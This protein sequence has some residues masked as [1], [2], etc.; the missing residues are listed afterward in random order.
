MIWP[1]GSLAPVADLPRNPSAVVF[2]LDGTLLDTEAGWLRAGA[3][4]SARYGHPFGADE[5]RLFVG[6]STE[7]ICEIMARRFGLPGQE[8]RLYDELIALVGH[9]LQGP[10]VP[11]PGAAELVAALAGRIPIA[12]ATN[13]TRALLDQVLASS[14]LD[15]FFDASV[16]VDEVRS[17]KPQPDVYQAAFGLLGARPEAA[18]AVEDSFTGLEAA[19]AAGGFVITVPPAATSGGGD[20]AF[21]TLA[22][23]ELLEWARA[24]PSVVG[25]CR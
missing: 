8:A 21:S 7:S 17:P 13:S 5:E 23:P 10:A 15:G 22:D 6:L 4:L 11:M 14:G 20:R 25:R 1:G 19:R 16:A 12:V 24:V 3:A 9:E 2:D 18:V